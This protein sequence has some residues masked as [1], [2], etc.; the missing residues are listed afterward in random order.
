MHWTISV[1]Q[2]IYNSRNSK[3]VIDS[4]MIQKY[5]K[6]AFSITTAKILCLFQKNK[7]TPPPFKEIFKNIAQII[8]NQYIKLKNKI[9]CLYYTID[10]LQNRKLLK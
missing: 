2:C 6:S 7:F 1:Y 10:L 4:N 5:Q 9:L 3:S 8:D